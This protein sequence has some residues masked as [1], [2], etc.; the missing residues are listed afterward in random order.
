MLTGP[1]YNSSSSKSKRE[2][3]ERERESI[4]KAQI[5]G[6]SMRPPLCTDGDD[7]LR[8]SATVGN[9][10]ERGEPEGSICP[11]KLLYNSFVCYES[12]GT[13]F[14]CRRILKLMTMTLYGHA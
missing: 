11:T 5:T 10:G 6:V 1:K 13:G 12:L 14:D 7:L 3:R 4:L 9:V 2:R 8:C